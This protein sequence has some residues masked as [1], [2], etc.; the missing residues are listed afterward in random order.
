MLKKLIRVTLICT[1]ICLSML[2]TNYS[3]A[4]ASNTIPNAFRGTW[5]SY[6]HNSCY[7]YL[8]LKFTKHAF[9]YK[10]DNQKWSWQ[11]LHRWNDK[12]I[13]KHLS[14]PHATMSI[15]R[16]SMYKVHPWMMLI[17]WQSNGQG[18]WFNVHTFSGRSV[19]TTMQ[20]SQI[21]GCAHYY[22]TKALAKQLYKVK[23][24]NF[25]Y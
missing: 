10:I 19:L 21:G 12:L 18:N 8:S 7:R 13:T 11:F 20:G 1:G 6:C 23:Y 3:N 22:K 9:A 24:K 4:Y 16:H 17:S 2:F 25:R 5:Y 15:S 14:K